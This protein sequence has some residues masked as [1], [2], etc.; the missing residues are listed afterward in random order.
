[1]NDKT[2]L[3]PEQVGAE[4]L[5]D[6]RYMLRTLRARF[7]TG[8]FTTGATLVAAIGEAADAMNHHPDLDLRYPRLDVVLTSHDSDGVTARDIR[9]ARTISSLAAS[10]DVAAAPD[11]VQ[12]LEIALDTPD[13][14]RIKPFWRSLLGYADAPRPDELLDPGARNPALWF[15]EATA[16]EAPAQRFHFDVH[17]P[18]EQA[19]TRIEAALAAGGTLVDDTWAPSFT[20][21]ADADGNRACVCT[22]QDPAKEP[23]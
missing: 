13:H 9:L 18:P 5:A 6:W 14:E 2:L 20:V 17:V 10:L 21:L 12:L 4:E 7:L 8:D 1:M 16:H 22:W 19:E 23:A 3:T 15:Q 11:Q